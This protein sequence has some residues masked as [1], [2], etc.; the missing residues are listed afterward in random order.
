M[1]TYKEIFGKKIQALSADPPAAQGEGQIW[2]NSTSNTFKTAT[3][4]AAW[5]SGGALP[6]ALQTAGGFGTQTSAVQAGG[7]P[8]P[9]Y[10]TV[11]N[12]Y[13]G[14]SWSGAAT[15]ARTSGGDGASTAGAGIL[16]AGWI[17][18]GGSPTA[19]DLTENYDGTSWTASGTMAATRKGG[20]ASGPQTAGIYFGG[21]TGAP[22]SSGNLKGETYLYDGSTWTTSPAT[23]STARTNASSTGP[24]GSQT[25]ALM[26][27]GNTPSQTANVEEFNGSTWSEETNF[28]RSASYVGYAGSQTDVIGFTGYTSP[29]SAVTTTTG[30]DGTSWSGKPS[31]ASARL[32][33]HNNAGTGT[34]ALCFGG[35][36][37]PGIT[38]AVEEYT[39]AAAVKTITTS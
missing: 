19:N 2:Y 17:A 10:N 21:A 25:A 37:I 27:C 33:Y 12:E 1:A 8:G 5:A 38:A 35:E 7:S 32:N 23:L 24:T 30:Y 22:P 15:L 31:M 4:S 14:S 34:A 20:N 18:G 3:P 29:G 36:A 26:F 6:T 13:N 11:S 28:P 9:S 39:D 16:T